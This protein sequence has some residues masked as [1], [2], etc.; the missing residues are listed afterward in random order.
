MTFK[1][2]QKYRYIKRNYPEIDFMIG[3]KTEFFLKCDFCSR[4]LF[5]YVVVSKN[6]IGYE[7][8]TG[9]NFH[10]IDGDKSND[11]DENIQ[12]LCEECHKKFHEWGS[13][14]KWLKKIKKSVKD[15][16]DYN[17]KPMIKF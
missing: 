10:H 9:G 12:F 14:R 13:I 1:S 17:L 7:S 3:G 4:P 16:P 8:Y 2:D 15:L 5:G 6:N 11:S